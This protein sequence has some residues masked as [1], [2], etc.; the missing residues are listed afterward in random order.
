M[1]KT[2]AALAATVLIGTLAPPA[3]AAARAA[4]PEIVSID[5]VQPTIDVSN[6]WAVATASLH[7]RHPTGLEDTIYAFQQTT[8]VPVVV[9][10]RADAPGYEPGPVS[11]WISWDTFHRV[12]GTATDG[13]WQS[14]LELSPAWHGEYQVFGVNIFSWSEDITDGP[15]L[16]VTGGET[17]AATSIPDPIRV[18]TGTERWR[19]RTRV[20]STVTGLPVGGARIYQGSA[21]GAQFLVRRTTTPGPAVDANGVWTAPTTVTV[22]QLDEEER[23]SLYLFGARGS[24]GWSLQGIGCLQPSIRLQASSAYADTTLVDDQALT[25]TG[26]VWPAPAITYTGAVVLLQRNLGPAGWQTVATARPR[27]NG[28]YTINWLP[29]QPGTHEMRVRVPG[30]GTPQCSPALLG[31]SLAGR[32]V[33]VVWTAARR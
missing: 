13:V 1:K 11:H 33:S 27:D 15:A 19:P 3:A 17:W 21:G 8:S 22:N 32:A 23:W 7:L 6:G 2:L 25:V 5:F 30:N 26:N 4:D 24:R 18:V 31:T 16:T 9:A 14:S 20:T 12:S 10:R 28:R 29:L